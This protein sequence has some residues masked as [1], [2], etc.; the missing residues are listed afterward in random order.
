VHDDG[1][2]AFRL[3]L[4]G[5]ILGGATVL[6]TG[7]IVVG[8]TAGQ[9]VAL[10]RE[11]RQLWTSTATGPVSSTPAE[12]LDGNVYVSSDDGRLTALD[13]ETGAV[14]WRVQT[15]GPFRA[16]PIIDT[17]GRIYIGSQ[18][19]FVYCIDPDGSVR[20]QHR[21]GGEVDSTGA[22]GPDGTYYTGCDDGALHALR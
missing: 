7:A 6:E 14:R 21:L 1:R 5:T 3:Q 18:D 2:D 4:E 22:I 20:W 16:S 17:A 12:G 11:G 15:G 8:T 13:P 10:D 19:R 9:V